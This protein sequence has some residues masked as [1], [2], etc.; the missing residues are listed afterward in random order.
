MEERIKLI[1]SSEHN[2]FQWLEFAGRQ[3]SELC[4]IR[5]VENRNELPYLNVNSLKIATIYN[6]DST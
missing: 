3:I 1:C 2:E 4:D 5:T 6:V